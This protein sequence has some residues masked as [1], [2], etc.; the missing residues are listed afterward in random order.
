MK[1]LKLKKLWLF[2]GWIQIAFVILVSLIPSPT[3]TPDIVGLDKLV[4]FSIYAF[5]MFWFGLCYIPGRAYNRIGFGIIMMG[6]ILEL[7]Q[8][9]TGYRSLSY[10]DMMS[11][12]FGVSLGWLLARTRLSGTLFHVEKMLVDR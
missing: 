1:E 2:I 4:H 12:A 3:D 5:L 6:I 11:N 8:G 9:K 7:I 10:F